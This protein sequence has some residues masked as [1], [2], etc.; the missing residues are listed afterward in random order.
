MDA[1]L[2]VIGICADNHTHLD[3]IDLLFWSGSSISLIFYIKYNINELIKKF[4]NIKKYDKK[5]R[6]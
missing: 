3:L 2:H 6:F 4:R 5:E 1:V